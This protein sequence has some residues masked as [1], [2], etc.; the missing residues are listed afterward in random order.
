M[1]TIIL[2]FTI[3]QDIDEDYSDVYTELVVDDIL[4]NPDAFGFK[5]VSDSASP[6]KNAEE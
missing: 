6:S 3:P 1:R 5:I 4:E 2:E